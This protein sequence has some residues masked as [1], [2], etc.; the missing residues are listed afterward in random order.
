MLA[1]GE[2]VFMVRKGSEWRVMESEPAEAEAESYIFSAYSSYGS[3][4]ALGLRS[5]R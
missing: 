4:Y 3:H 1:S 5:V 2:A